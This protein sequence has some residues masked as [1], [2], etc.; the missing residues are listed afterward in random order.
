MSADDV[1]SDQWF[2]R[3]TIDAGFL[4]AL[5]LAAV[6]VGLYLDASGYLHDWNKEPGAAFLTCMVLVPVLGV[7]TL[8]LVIYG[9][10]RIFLRPHT[11]GH[12]FV[13]SMLLIAHAFVFLVCIDTISTTVTSVARGFR[14][15]SSQTGSSSVWTGLQNQDFSGS[16]Y[17]VREG[18]PDDSPSS[19]SRFAPGPMGPSSGRGTPSR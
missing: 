12:V 3:Y 7:V 2:T 9:G 14:E 19:P 1:S 5:V 16:Q 13:R 6:G 15:L 10:I 4:V 18:S 17:D 8:G 11:L